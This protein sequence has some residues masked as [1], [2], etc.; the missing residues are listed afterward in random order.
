MR[1]NEESAR[2][3]APQSRRPS[4]VD[5]RLALAGPA[6]RLPWRSG[7]AA[8]ATEVPQT[9]ILRVATALAGRS[10]A[11]LLG[12]GDA[13]QRGDWWDLLAE[14]VRL[15]P[16][17]LGLCSSG[18]GVTT[19]TA[20]RL[21]AHGV[22]RLQVP[23]HCARQDA[24][25]WLVGEPGALKIAH[26]AIR[27]AVEAELPVTAEIVLTRPT[28][29]HLGETIEVLARSG[30]RSICV[31]RL[32]GL[33][34]EGAEFV[35]LSARL[36]L[37][38]DSLEHAATL[39]LE[40]RVRV[41]L[42]D[43][44]LCVAPRLRPLFAAPESE[45][46][47]LPDGS[48]RVRGAAGLGC[49]TCPGM[50]ECAGAPDD[51][52]ARF[53][54]EE[55]V[56]PVT[57]E[58]RIHESVAAQQREAAP[59]TLTFTWRGPHRVRCEACAATEYDE[60]HAQHAYEATR[61]VRAR[62]VEAARYRPARLR[63]VGAD[64]LAHPQAALLIYDALRL[65][66]RVEVAGEASAIV[67]WSE[68]DLRRLKELQRI[69]L[70]FYGPDAATHDAH[71][72]IPGAFAA[73]LRGAERLRSETAIALGAYAIVHDAR[74]VPA[75]ADAWSRGV[76]PG[77]PRFRLSARGGALHELVECAGALPSGAA[78]EALL[79][80]LPRCLG[81]PAGL[82][83]AAGS[84][85][86][87]GRADRPQQRIYSGRSVAYLPCGSD[88]IGAFETCQEGAEACAISG[89][90]GTAVGWHS[91]ARAERWSTSI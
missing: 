59:D 56:N 34:T 26:R 50:P 44:P 46:W 52:A 54:W 9:E 79:A 65:Y 67:D 42:R 2:R 16:A 85:A 78:R 32:H 70:A 66:R 77:Q 13:L 3:S 87:S 90:P 63:L 43:L 11:F 28:M 58:P 27:A 48:A 10:G 18:H 71:C 39:A 86:L 74:L 81:E 51:Y 24:H 72:G 88:P 25:D 62:L 82:R 53:G 68:L 20:R 5:V 37:I 35:P 40:R 76:L 55:F 61:T 38:G 21:L 33:D 23:F 75:F 29:R 1:L 19:E 12:G 47:A 69:D 84:D 17:N 36:E 60:R 80:V 73:T 14:L 15:R 30:V 89:C 41:R 45:L 64:L 31:R 8:A 91:S 4:S 49:A 57:A 7:R 6:M 83:P 22:Q